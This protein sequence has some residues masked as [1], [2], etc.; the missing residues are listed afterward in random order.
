MNKEDIPCQ[1]EEA[2]SFDSFY[3][4]TV[5]KIDG[6]YGMINKSGDTVLK[7]MFDTYST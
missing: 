5:V 3:P 7:P 4:Y 1:Y 2:F 6:K